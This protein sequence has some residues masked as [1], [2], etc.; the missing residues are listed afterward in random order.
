MSWIQKGSDIIGLLENDKI[1]GERLGY[2]VSI[3]SNGNILAIGCPYDNKKK[4]CVRVYYWNVNKWT[5]KGNDIIG[6]ST[7]DF[8]GFSISM[9]SDGNIIAIGAPFNDGGAKSGGHVRVYYW[10][11]NKWS[12]KGN[13]IN[14]SLKYAQSGN[15]VSLS[16]NG[17]ILAIGAP[18]EAAGEGVVNVF[19]WKKNSW[20]KRGSTL[21]GYHYLN[22]FGYSVDLSKNGNIL[23]IGEPFAFSL[24]GERV[25]TV[26]IYNWINNKWLKIGNDIIGEN[27]NSLCGTSVS[28]NDNGN[29][30]AIG[31]PE[32]SF[33]G[34]NN[35]NV[36]VFDLLNSEWVQ[37]GTNINGKTSYERFGKK[38]KIS[39]NGNTLI[40]GSPMFTSDE[41]FQSGKVSI[42]QWIDNN[43]IENSQIFT[44][45]DSYDGYGKSIDISGDAKTI[46]IGS[47][48]ISD[49]S[50]SLFEEGKI[51][52]GYAQIY[53][54]VPTNIIKNIITKEPFAKK[55]IS[56]KINYKIIKN[57]K[58]IIL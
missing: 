15:S 16:S 20:V 38:V 8:S 48:G 42:Y 51:P 4:G 1:N 33:E 5:K 39:E 9:S 34:D 31:S 30:I 13:D 35:G 44:A 45:K 21:K 6:E 56:K 43:W 54:L 26:R 55:N 57:T 37:R 52:A 49:I 7:L 36:R 18:T 32:N 12:K 41:N 3:N 17:N 53:T 2:S 58:K 40:I 46:I 50:G 24:T 27:Y 22:Q 14:N 28:L 47:P 19:E 25:G 10:N 11:K 23:A 29:T